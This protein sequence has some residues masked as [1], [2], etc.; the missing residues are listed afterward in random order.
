M[1]SD[2]KGKNVVIGFLC[3]AIA[4]M[5]IGFAVLS[6][7]LN[8]TGTATVKTNNWDIHFENVSNKN[9][10]GSTTVTAEPTIDSVTT[11]VNYEITLNKPGDAYSFTV[12][13]TNNGSIDA[14]L[15]SF[16]FGGVSTEQDVYIN[17]SVTGMTEGEVLV[18]GAKKT[19]T[20]NVEY[21]PNINDNQLP[22]SDQSLNLTASLNFGQDN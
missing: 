15:N 2:S 18:A 14:K 13:V 7:N 22:T 11:T 19:I 9:S 3:I 20:V 8:I 4:M 5:S 6:S 1:R 10:V 21:D 17:Y 16:V 12:D